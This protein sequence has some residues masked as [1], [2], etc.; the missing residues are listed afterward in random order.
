MNEIIKNLLRS[1]NEKITDC[2]HRPCLIFILLGCKKP[3][4]VAKKFVSAWKSQGYENDG[5]ALHPR[6]QKIY[7]VCSLC[8]RLKML[9]R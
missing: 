9:P 2:N 1:N 8:L 4:S 7:W 6:K 5:K 3:E